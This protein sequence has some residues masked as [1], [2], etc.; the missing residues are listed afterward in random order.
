M[1]CDKRIIPAIVLPAM[2]LLMMSCGTEV[3]EVDIPVKASQVGGYIDSSMTW[4][5]DLSPYLVMS[6]VIVDSHAVLTVDPG[7]EIRFD[8]KMGIVVLGSMIAD[9]TPDS[10]ILFSAIDGVWSGLAFTGGASDTLSSLSYCIIE[11]CNAGVVCNSLTSPTIE[12]CVIQ[13]FTNIGIYVGYL[14]EAQIVDND[15]LDPAPGGSSMGVQCD[16]YAFPWI[17]G[18]RIT[19][20]AQGIQCRYV[21]FTIIDSNYIADCDT[22][23]SFLY[24]YNTVTLRGSNLEG[25]NVGIGLVWS[26]PDITDNSIWENTKAMQ[27]GPGSNPYFHQN[28]LSDNTWTVFNQTPNRIDAEQNWWGTTDSTMIAAG[29]WDRYDTTGIGIVDFVP[30]LTAPP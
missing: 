25:N 28:D 3:T 17:H 23:V 16:P 12:H 29:I 6:P 22:G 24:T 30:V 21:S 1:V 27:P 15:I 7:V 10:M 26:S 20:H 2:L 19:G 11:Y 13:N 5:L 4:T 9:G 18:N 14:A 8:W